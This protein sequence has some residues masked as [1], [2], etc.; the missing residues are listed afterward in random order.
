MIMTI[1]QKEDQETEDKAFENVDVLVEL[2][3]P[4]VETTPASSITDYN[5]EQVAKIVQQFSYRDIKAVFVRQVKATRTMTYFF[6]LD[7][8]RLN[9]IIRIDSTMRRI[10]EIALETSGISIL[11]PVP[12]TSQIAVIVP[13]KGC[14]PVCLS[15]FIDEINKYKHK[16]PCVLG[17]DHLGHPR[18][19]DLAQCHHQL[20]AGATGSGKSNS[21][22]AIITAIAMTCD[23]RHLRLL[24][25]DGKGIDLVA[26]DKIPHLLCPVITERGKAINALKWLS[27]EMERRR[28]FLHQQNMSDIWVYNEQCSQE[29]EE[30]S[31]DSPEPLPAILLVI[32][33]VQVLMNGKNEKAESLLRRITQQ[34]RACGIIVVLSTQRPS[35]DIIQGS[36]KINLPGRIAF[37]LPSN[38][39]SRVILDQTGA[40]LLRAKGDSLV[41]ESSFSKTMRLQAP[42]VT[43][44]E[45]EE[46]CNF[47]EAIND[48][49][50]EFTNDN[51]SFASEIMVPIN[52]NDK[53][54]EDGQ[55]QDIVATQSETEVYKIPVSM[56]A[57][58]VMTY[59]DVGKWL[60]KKYPD[61]S[62]ETVLIYYPFIYGEVRE[63]ARKFSILYDVRRGNFVKSFMPLQ[64]IE[65]GPIFKSLNGELEVFSFMRKSNSRVVAEK[66]IMTSNDENAETKE[67]CITKLVEKGLIGVTSS[68]Y[69]I[70][71]DFAQVPKLSKKLHLTE[72]PE[73]PSRRIT[74]FCCTASEAIERLRIQLWKIWQATLESHLFIGLPIYQAVSKQDDVLMFVACN[75]IWKLTLETLLSRGKRDCTS[76]LNEILGFDDENEAQRILEFGSVP[77]SVSLTIKDTVVLPSR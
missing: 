9:D 21:L 24:L 66:D 45:I 77:K 13:I 32:D 4:S 7:E 10:L 55:F 59:R 23:Y 71:N 30:Q 75:P 19:I 48:D 11:A 26:F 47:F 34:G 2:D 5:N 25:V 3:V 38:A 54:D 64:V 15:S 44:K 8:H 62:W 27:K 52:H 39:D 46:V 65:I 49:H 36:I 43:D 1:K 29:A 50:N 22:K 41:I 58:T 56:F 74:D 63:E 57:K 60:N 14:E 53:I 67:A 16:I 31:E 20:I 69:F 70:Q 73:I 72:I 42:L 61:R 6:E 12:E 18:V 51:D 17:E 37:S 28:S 35:V 68:G 33:E 40:E 76:Q